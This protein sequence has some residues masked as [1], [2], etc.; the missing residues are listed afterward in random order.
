MR[1][2]LL[3]ARDPGAANVVIPLYNKLK[4]ASKFEAVL[5]GKDFSL[6]SYKKEGLDFIDVGNKVYDSH[7]A[8]VFLKEGN[9]SLVLTGTTADDYTDRYL[10][11]GAKELGIKS[12]AVLDQ[13]MNYRTRFELG[14]PNK[15]SKSSKLVLPDYICVM[16][17]LAKSEMIKEGIP[18]KHIVITGQP[19]FETVKNRIESLSV[20]DISKF[21]DKYQIDKDDI[22]LVFASEEI[23]STYGKDY[24]GYTEKTVLKD[25]IT[26]LKTI[27][28]STNKK[29]YLSIKLHPRNQ[30]NEFEIYRKL[31]DSNLHIIITKEESRQIVISSADL[32][33]GMTSMFLLEAI[34]ANKPILNV[35]IGLKRENPFVLSRLG[36]TKTL[37]TADELDIKLKDFLIKGNKQNI[38]FDLTTKPTD[39]VI[40]I[41][42]HALE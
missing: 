37:T 3:Y 4:D 6:E 18:S 8:S 11:Q 30:P 34:V 9:F 16:D 19:Y 26:S 5:V 17:D 24:Y 27:C 14:E 13:W 20:V 12:I 42:D 41:V 35:Q 38:L 33:I 32:V 28:K 36:Y 1:K 15:S 2:I 31:S 22:D 29:I 40:Q 25:L 23:E 10:W 7:S 21:K 39:K